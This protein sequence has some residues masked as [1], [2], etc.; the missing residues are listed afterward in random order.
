MEAGSSLL[1]IFTKR[2]NRF[3]LLD[4]GINFISNSNLSESYILEV[5]CAYGDGSSYLVKKYNCRAEG[6]DI[7][8]SI[9]ASAKDRHRNLI[10]EGNLNFISGNAEKLPYQNDTFDILFSEAAFSP[11]INKE[12]AV[13][14]YY[15]VLKKGGFIIINDFATKIPIYAKNR[16]DVYIPCF[17]GVNTV[18]NYADI[19][20]KNDFNIISA[21]EEYGELL[22]ISMWVS[23]SFNIDIGEIGTY[24]NRYYNYNREKSNCRGCIEKNNFLEK[25]KL[26]YCQMILE[27]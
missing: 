22:G 9:I 13:S 18:E 14:E 21:K 15:R 8:E 19:F 16:E 17:Q 26:T 2:P 23:K 3:R 7:S 10:F 5:G 6:I 25:I 1:D 20:K 4:K 12:N 11:I 24:L 27:K